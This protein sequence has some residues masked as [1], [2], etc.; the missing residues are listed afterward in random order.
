MNWKLISLGSIGIF[1]M[2][3]SAL[4]EA[5]NRQLSVDAG[6]KAITL[7]SEETNAELDDANSKIK[8]CDELNKRENKEINDQ[9]NAWKK[10]NNYENRKRE[11]HR[12]AEN[13]LVEFKDSISY[14]DKKQAIIDEAEDELQAFKESIDYDYE[15]KSREKIIDDAKNLY[16]KKCK[17]YDTYSDDADTAEDAA[18]MKAKAKAVMDESIKDAKAEINEF[19]SKAEAEKNKINRKKQADLRELESELQAT[20]TRLN[21]QEA[22]QI[23]AIEKEYEDAKNDIRESVY[24]KR[25]EDEIKALETYDQCKERLND[26]K[27]TDADKAMDIYNNTPTHEKMAAFLKKSKCPKWFVGLIA[28]LPM[29]PAGYLIEQYCA[30]VF[31]TIKAM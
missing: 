31:K 17:V 27:I 16:K 19:K 21:K 15:V 24:L 30:F 6:E 25:T 20:K 7:H 3:I 18:T 22:E 2:I 5:A 26:Q 28:V 14:Y 23:A 13:E 4:N 1:W 11:I 29:V 8:L 12:A 9:T 10:L